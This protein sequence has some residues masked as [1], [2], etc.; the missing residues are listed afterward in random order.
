[1]ISLK[2]FRHF[3]LQVLTQENFHTKISGTL[4]G[5]IL[6]TDAT[7]V[8]E[9]ALLEMYE[10]AGALRVCTC[11]HMSPHASHS[12]WPKTSHSSVSDNL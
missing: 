1:M 7:K 8:S 5:L 9:L 2:I 10:A 3:F 4:P 6:F 11:E 12:A